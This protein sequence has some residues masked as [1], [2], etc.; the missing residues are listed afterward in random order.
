MLHPAADCGWPW[1]RTC[2]TAAQLR[3]NSVNSGRPPLISAIE[4]F[5]NDFC[6]A[7]RG[8][9]VPR[10]AA[11]RRAGPAGRQHQPRRRLSLPQ[12]CDL[13]DTE[14]GP[15][16]L[17]PVR[18][19]WWSATATRLLQLCQCLQRHREMRHSCCGPHSSDSCCSSRCCRLLQQMDQQMH[20]G[21]RQLTSCSAGIWFFIRWTTATLPG[22]RYIRWL[23]AAAASGCHFSC[24]TICAETVST[25]AAFQSLCKGGALSHVQL[26]STQ[27]DAPVCSCGRGSSP[28]ACHGTWSTRAR[29]CGTTSETTPSSRMCADRTH[30]IMWPSS[31]T[32]RVQLAGPLHCALLTKMCCFQQ[33]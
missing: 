15:P 19:S 29:A 6:R 33:L 22:P 11:G 12:Q 4:S 18:L 14:G 26:D 9:A 23:H 28:T 5:R 27:C 25:L 10:A 8:E 2:Y 30:V 21:D 16:Q 31:L 32:C 7:E 20:Q 17:H 24:A 13:G 3:H 1:L